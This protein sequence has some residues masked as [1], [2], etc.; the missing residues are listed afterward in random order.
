VI[1]PVFVGLCLLPARLSRNEATFVVFAGLKGA[2]PLLLGSYL[3]TTTLGDAPRLF[4]IVVVVVVTSVAVQ[5]SLVPFVARVLHLQMRTVEPQPWALGVRLDREPVGVH[6]MTVQ[7]GSAADGRSIADLAELPDDAW[8]SL[9]VRDRQLVGVSSD[10]M[11]R[12]GDEV[13]VLAP[14]ERAH[15]LDATFRK[16]V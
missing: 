12:A 6:R 15:D 14:P 2:V 7:T 1:R 3:L 4:A 5:G 10:T 16:P 8:I 13:M 9:V 11:L